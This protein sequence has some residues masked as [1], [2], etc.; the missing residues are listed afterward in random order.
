[1]L[2]HVVSMKFKSGV[3]EAEIDDLEKSLDELPNSVVEIQ[4]YEFGRDV[5]HTERSYDFAIVALFSNE[6]AL[7]R[8]QK[9]PEH[10]KVL[11]K[12]KKLCESVIA[13]DFFG[14]DAGDFKDKTQLPPLL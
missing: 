6:E 9:H 10:L 5:L 14:T 1:M 8:Y 7:R 13:V 4:M 11:E 3:T 2:N 12:I